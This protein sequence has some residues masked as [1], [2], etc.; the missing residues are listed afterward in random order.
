MISNKDA[1]VVNA[2]GEQW[3]RF[4]QSC[5]PEQELQEIFE[6][7]FLIFPW[8]ILPENSIGLDV[9]CG[10]G[11]WAKM[12]APK[13]GLLHC[14]DASKAALDV[15]KENLAQEQNCQFHHASVDDIPLPDESAD[16]AYSLGVFHHVPNTSDGI[17][18]CVK[19][20]KR[21][22]PFLL[23]LY[24][25]MDNKPLWYKWLWKVS[26]IIRFCVSRMVFPLRLFA[27]Q[28]IALL[29]YLPLARLALFL[30]W[31]GLNVDYMPISEYKKRSFYFMRTDALDRFG[32]RLEKRFTK[33]Q[34]LEMLEEVGLKNIS[35]SESSPYWLVVGYKK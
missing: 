1:K 2:F 30:E 19:K 14:I 4:D 32:T 28:V 3:N 10:S 25:A 5:L 20:I 8:D 29:V 13:V 9:G 33:N 17:K 26:E 21:G 24:Y 22:A 7:Y 16:F 15:A 27:S 34:I 11:R 6:S 31:V 35:F 18:S 23:Y 12:V